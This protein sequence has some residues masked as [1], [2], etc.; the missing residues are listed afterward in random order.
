MAIRMDVGKRAND[1][2]REHTALVVRIGGCPIEMSEMI[3][4]RP[5]H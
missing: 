1:A 3:A 5:E 2:A 4:A